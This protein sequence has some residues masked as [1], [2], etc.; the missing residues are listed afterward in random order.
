MFAL[1]RDFQAL[2]AVD[3]GGAALTGEAVEST[4][5]PPGSPSMSFSPAIGLLLHWDACTTAQL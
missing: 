3:V 4:C 1:I 2:Q 5:A